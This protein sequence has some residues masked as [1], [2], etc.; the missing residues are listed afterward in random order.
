MLLR[1]AGERRFLAIQA[2]LPRKTNVVHLFSVVWRRQ[3]TT[4][5]KKEPKFY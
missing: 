1:A 5:E 3:T 2:L 4:T